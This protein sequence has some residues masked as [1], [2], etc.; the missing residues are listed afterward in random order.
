M[1]PLP[2][3]ISPAQLLEELGIDSP[4]DIDIEAIAQYCGAT[5][6]YAPLTGCEA[7]IIGYHDRAIIT[8]HSA[9]S[10]SRRRFSGG[11][12]LGHWMHDRGKALA[13][14]DIQLTSEWFTDNPEKRA[15]RYAADL[16]MPVFMF[17]PIADNRPIIFSTVDELTTTFQTSITATAIRLVE[18]GAFPSMVICSDARRRKWFTR[19]EIL[20]EALRPHEVLGRDTVAFELHRNQMAIP[21]GPTEVNAAQWISHPKASLYTVKE[22][23]IR[24][25]SGLVLTLLWWQDEQQLLDLMNEQEEEDSEE[26]PSPYDF[27]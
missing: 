7:R 3:P 9:A 14:S 2:R 4:A 22:D 23:S 12:E 11:H 6:V 25:S 15:N 10:F 24:V 13:C 19:S 5:I 8:I 20:P 26:E 16:L 27:D 21:P 18:H 1:S 17:K